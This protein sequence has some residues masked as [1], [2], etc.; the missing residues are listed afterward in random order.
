MSRSLVDG[1]KYIGKESNSLE[2][3][4]SGLFHSTENVYTEYAD[5]RRDGWEQSIVLPFTK[6]PCLCNKEKLVCPAECLSMLD[7]A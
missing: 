7:W 5:P 6:F 4:D 1:I 2:E 3:D